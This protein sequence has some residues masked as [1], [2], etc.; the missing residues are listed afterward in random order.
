[1]VLDRDAMRFVF[2]RVSAERFES[3]VEAPL[4]RKIP[5][6]KRRLMARARHMAKKLTAEVS[7]KRPATSGPSYDFSLM[8]QDP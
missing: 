3:T 1:M 8:S 7:A 6:A 4:R 2:N 5:A